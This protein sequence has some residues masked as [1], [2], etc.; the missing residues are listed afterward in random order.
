MVI[1]WTAMGY[2]F[3]DTPRQFYEKNKSNIK[4]S[5]KQ[6]KFMHEIFDRLENYRS[7]FSSL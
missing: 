5:E 4:L 7:N 2:V 3:N 6:K 1:D